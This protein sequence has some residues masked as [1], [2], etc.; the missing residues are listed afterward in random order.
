MSKYTHTYVCVY[1]YIYV[2]VVWAFIV[3]YGR[4]WA[5]L[6][7]SGWQAKAFVVGGS[8]R[9]HPPTQR[10]QHPHLP[11]HPLTQRIQ[12]PH[13]EDTTSPPLHPE[14]PNAQL[15]HPPRGYNIPTQRVQPPPPLHPEGPIAP[16]PCQVPRPTW[17]VE[18]LSR[19]IGE[20]SPHPTDSID[21]QSCYNFT[22]WL[23]SVCQ[24]VL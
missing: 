2:C 10:I 21:S 17:E 8:N 14:G 3:W 7:A 18:R 20:P 24:S 11:I 1:S 22:C 16:S 13:P 6:S 12:H 23:N 4:V 15:T 5:F 19:P 9:P